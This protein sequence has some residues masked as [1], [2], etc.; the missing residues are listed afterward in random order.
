MS[1]PSG[2]PRLSQS[3]P[4]GFRYENHPTDLPPSNLP[5]TKS[6]TGHAL[7]AAMPDAMQD[8]LIRADALRRHVA[9]LASVASAA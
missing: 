3:A 9:C 5:I 1:S 8:L 7:F 4:I 6:C 2:L